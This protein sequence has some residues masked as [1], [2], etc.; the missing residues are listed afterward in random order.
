MKKFIKI[1]LFTYWNGLVLFHM[2]SCATKIIITLEK[3]LLVA[4]VQLLQR[5]VEY[6]E[7]PKYININY[8]LMNFKQF[9][10]L[11]HQILFRIK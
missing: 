11:K 7:Q 5:F 1:K 4:T 8:T 10:G 2:S 6:F 9:F 3:Q